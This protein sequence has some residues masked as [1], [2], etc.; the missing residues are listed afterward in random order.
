MR[1]PGETREPEE[2]R[3]LR[4]T[5]EPAASSPDAWEAVLDRLRRAAYATL[6]GLVPLGPPEVTHTAA[7]STPAPRPRRDHASISEGAF[8]SASTGSG[9]DTSGSGGFPASPADAMDF[10]VSFDDLV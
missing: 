5:L 4:E 8:G 10:D 9:F 3:E 7:A 6:A 2:M 1:E